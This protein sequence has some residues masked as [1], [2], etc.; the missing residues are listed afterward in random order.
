MDGWKGEDK[1]MDR[2]RD[3]IING[4]ELLVVNASVIIDAMPM[5][6]HLGHGLL[7]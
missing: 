3:E 2:W 7:I 6:C 1:G 4:G 5:S